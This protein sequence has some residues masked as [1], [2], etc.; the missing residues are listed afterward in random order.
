MFNMLINITLNDLN[1]YYDYHIFFN[2]LNQHI[3]I[4]YV[5]F[6]YINIYFSYFYI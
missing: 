2:N 4:I 3:I 5:L 6:Y 1:L